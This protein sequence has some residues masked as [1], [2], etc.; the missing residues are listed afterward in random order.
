[1]EVD[2]TD[3]HHPGLAFEPACDALPVRVQGHGGV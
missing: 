2:A 3:P 1:M